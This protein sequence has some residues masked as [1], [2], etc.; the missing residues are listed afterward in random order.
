MLANRL[1][2]AVRYLLYTQ[3]IRFAFYHQS[4]QALEA[5]C[6]AER[7][8]DDN[9]FPVKVL[10]KTEDTM[11][12][13]VRNGNVM[14]LL[15]EVE[16]ELL[17]L[18]EKLGSKQARGLI[19]DH[20]EDILLWV[21]KT[22]TVV[23][24]LHGVSQVKVTLSGANVKMNR[25]KKRKCLDAAFSYFVRAREN[26]R[27]LSACTQ[28]LLKTGNGILQGNI[29]TVSDLLSHRRFEIMLKLLIAVTKQEQAKLG[30]ADER[31]EKVN[32]ELV[33]L[34]TEDIHRDVRELPK[35]CDLLWTNRGS[36]LSEVDMVGLLKCMKVVKQWI[37][38]SMSDG[39]EQT[40]SEEEEEEKKE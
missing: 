4:T 13:N 30:P 12:E 2:V 32:S 24:F 26:C 11:D 25:G 21:Q 29:R 5:Q 33:D 9:Q 3:D 27:A 23:L 19:K 15:D 34:L 31:T 8:K 14:N 1:H 10:R 22:M 35:F 39:E 36:V 6:H 20:E 16:K 7:V 18:E 40:E 38:W 28:V 17:K 37:G